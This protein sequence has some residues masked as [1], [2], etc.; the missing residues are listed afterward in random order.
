MKKLFLGIA[1]VVIL[2]LAFI[3]VTSGPDASQLAALESFPPVISPA[4]PGIIAP[5]DEPLPADI[6]DAPAGTRE[7]AVQ[8]RQASQPRGLVERAGSSTSTAAR[9]P[10]R[11]R[12]DREL[13]R[14]SRVQRAPVFKNTVIL[15]DRSG[16][17]SGIDRSVMTAS[18]R[19]G[20]VRTKRKRSVISRAFSVTKKPYDWARSLISKL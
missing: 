1:A 7:L 4:A 11:A 16:A 2:D 3:F 17:E 9:V 6:A 10:N 15:Y 14:N 13:A 5:A 12:T 18:I 20:D 19:T 8:S